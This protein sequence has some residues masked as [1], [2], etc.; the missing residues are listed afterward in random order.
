MQDVYTEVTEDVAEGLDEASDSSP[1]SNVPTG[2][3]VQS[4]VRTGL[5]QACS[6]A[7]TYTSAGSSYLPSSRHCPDC[8]PSANTMCM[9]CRRAKSLHP[10]S[11]ES[12]Q[13]A[14]A[15]YHMPFVGTLCNALHMQCSA[16]AHWHSS[17]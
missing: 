8:C 11:N 4:L 6:L 9:R 15:K 7:I 3:L 12:W 10:Q 1:S 14:P 17:I 2:Q 13:A 5:A 16:H